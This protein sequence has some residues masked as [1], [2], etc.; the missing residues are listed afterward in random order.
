MATTIRVAESFFL[1][2]GFPVTQFGI[3]I[4]LPLYRR[5]LREC[6]T[7]LT[8]LPLHFSRTKGTIPTGNI[9]LFDIT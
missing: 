9:L 7:E 8:V 2:T 5:L 4:P 6:R 3:I 1:L